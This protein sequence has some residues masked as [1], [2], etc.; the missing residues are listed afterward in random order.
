M[1]TRAS[2]NPESRQGYYEHDGNGR[3]K[4]FSFQISYSLNHIRRREYS[5]ISLESL[6]SSVTFKTKQGLLLTG[7]VMMWMTG[8]EINK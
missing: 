6:I 3:R 8:I 2:G 7:D 5:I 4:S 1:D